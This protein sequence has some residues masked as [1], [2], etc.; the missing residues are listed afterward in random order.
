MVPG[1]RTVLA[2]ETLPR[3]TEF[4]DAETGAEK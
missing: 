2:I 4:L 3:G 1:R